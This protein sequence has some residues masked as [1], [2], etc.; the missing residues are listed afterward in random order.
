MPK[1][2]YTNA[3]RSVVKGTSKG[4]NGTAAGSA[5]AKGKTSSSGGGAVRQT[6]GKT[7]SGQGAGAQTGH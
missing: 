6:A 4:R 3:G 1:G 7:V 5:A 2:G